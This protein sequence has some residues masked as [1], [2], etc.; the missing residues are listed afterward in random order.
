[1]NRIALGIE[2][3][4]SGFSGWQSQAHGNTVQDVLERA[5]ARVANT[6]I[7]SICAGR[8]DAGVHATGQVVH[9]DTPVLRPLTAWVRG[10]NAHLP[11]TVAV[12]WAA[13]VELDFNARFS[14]IGRSYRYVLLNRSVRPG[15][16]NGRVGWFH[17][18]L[19]LGAMQ[20]ACALIVG[21][22]D[23]SAFRAAECQAKSPVRLMKS[24]S[25]QRE[26]DFI[27]FD[28]NA[29]AFLHHMVRNL[30]GAMVFIGAGRQPPS[31][32]ANLLE[33]KDR[34][35]AAPTFD[36]AGLYFTGPE[37]GPEWRLPS[38]DRMM[39]PSIVCSG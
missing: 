8:T 11:A 24:A 26:G 39:L 4:G 25:V 12:R 23:F 19:E 28:F 27:L 34:S 9:F 29:N 13:A 15:V 33:S 10:V 31:W 37:Y 3:D 21:E 36:P 30:V 1:M 38:P 17:R 14:A 16:L 6:E 35:R 2:Y 7:R 18:P 5:L 32:M 22:H 20:H